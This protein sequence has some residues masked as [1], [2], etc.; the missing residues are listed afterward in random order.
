MTKRFGDCQ[1]G[2]LTDTFPRRRAARKGTYS[3]V[4]RDRAGGAIG[5]AVQSHWFSVGALVPWAA[6]GVGGV[7]TQANVD[8]SYGPRLLDRLRS[9]QSAGEA[10]GELVAA[11]KE[12]VVRQ[13]A[14]VDSS[15]S[16]AAH[17]GN[18]CMPFAGHLV[19]DGFS[20]QA[21]LMAD[22]RVWPAMADAFRRSSASFPYRLLAALDAGEAA[23]GDVR[24]RQS[25]AILVVPAAGNPWDRIVDLRVEDNREP[26]LELRRLLGL[27]D[28]YV[29]AGEGDR[30]VG[31]GNLLEAAERYKQANATSPD[32]VELKFWGG[33]SMI[34]QGDEVSGLRLLT[35]AI[36]THRG[37]SELLARLSP[38]SG[39]GVVRARQLLRM[40][41][42]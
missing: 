23:G 1:G 28:A 38:S 39:P 33:L 35:E 14:V 37:W 42:A 5:V 8:V 36:A 41:S 16:V 31:E 32:S 10:L 6:P 29:L 34:A 9:G 3:I 27:H 18:E 26:L 20:C 25:A 15:G 21:N 24:G 22:Q 19:D 12:A 2:R 13:I 7:A 4:A 17:T 30:L 40:S 11:D